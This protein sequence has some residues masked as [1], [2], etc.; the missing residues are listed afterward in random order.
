M[1]TTLLA[2]ILA[3]LGL[4]VLAVRHRVAAVCLVTGQAMVLMALAFHDAR[5]TGDLIAASALTARTLLLAGLFGLLIRNTRD[6]RLVHPGLGLVRRIGAG[7][8]LALVLIWLVPTIGLGTR[9]IEQAILAV[10][11]LGLVI[12][13]TSRATLQQILGIVVVENALVLAALELPGTSWLIELGLAFDLVLLAA[14]AGA[15][16]R[17]IVA[18]FG[19]GDTAA[20]RSLRD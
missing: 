9:A 13:A 12:A 7:I 8:A 14:V 11:A 5:E 1:T 6:T 10:V 17:R 19:A 20:L 4:A 2:W 15:F 3:G 16:H 18:Q